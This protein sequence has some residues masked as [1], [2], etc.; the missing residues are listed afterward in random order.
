MKQRATHEWR[1]YHMK[2]KLED[3]IAFLEEKMSS[4]KDIWEKLVMEQERQRTGQTELNITK[5]LSQN[6]ERAI[7]RLKE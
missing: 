1:F 2:R 3:K 6:N 7:D 4:N 5:K